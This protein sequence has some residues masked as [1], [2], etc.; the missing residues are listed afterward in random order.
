M[1]K[2]GCIKAL[3]A[4]N[5]GLREISRKIKRSLCVV[6]NYLSSPDSYGTQKRSGRKRKLDQ[7][8]QRRIVRASSNASISLNQLRAM[9][10]NKISRS[11]VWRILKRTDFIQYKKRKLVTKL[12]AKHKEARL[13]FAR[14]NVDTNWNRVRKKIN[15]KNLKQIDIY[16]FNI[17]FS[18]EKKWN[19]DGPDGSRGY[20][21]DIR[22]EPLTCTKRNFGGGNVMTWAAFSAEGCLEIQIVSSRMKSA[23]YIEVLEK[24]LIPFLN[25]Q[26]T[27]EW[28]FQ[29]DNARIHV[30]RETK[31]WFTAK[32]VQVMEW[33]ACSPDL[34]PIENLWGI[35]S[36]R[37]YANN[38]QFN[39]I[40]ELIR[41]IKAEWCRIEPGIITNLIGSMIKRLND[42]LLKGGDFIC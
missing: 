20:Y 1:T 41:A 9:I 22:Q 33:P 13:Q 7:T 26:D 17:V 32:G 18:D 27:E 16:H 35:L 38:R 19:L 37:V 34:N 28:I 11:T 24:A 30:S 12:T 2:K 4:E 21:H 10:D 31:R 39:S 15:V 14:N 8:A 42:V 23:D 36:Q 25:G 29:Q 40:L 6:Q 3:H 5:Y